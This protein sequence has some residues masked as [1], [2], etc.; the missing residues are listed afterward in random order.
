MAQQLTKEK[1][2]TIVMCGKCGS[3]EVEIRAWVSPNL[4]NAFSM[5][6]DGGTLEDAE[7][8]YCHACGEWTSPAFEQE[9]IPPADPWRCEECGSLNV[10]R[11]ISIDVNSN[12]VDF[13]SLYDEF[14]CGDCE[15]KSTIRQSELISNIDDWF[16]NDL[17]PENTEIIS[18]LKSDSYA[19]E[20]EYDSA[21]RE[22]WDARSV[23]EKIKIWSDFN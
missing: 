14:L 11:K 12:D 21:C 17:Q 9:A 19:S 8:C 16:E 22:W 15:C 23:E 5:Y 2:R 18:E 13:G 3:K 6:Y 4:D 7:T 20:M 1:M 10:E